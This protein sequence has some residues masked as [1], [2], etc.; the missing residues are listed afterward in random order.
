MSRQ[1][2]DFERISRYTLL[3]SVVNAVPFATSLPTATATVVVTVKD[4]NEAPVFSPVQKLVV[5]KEDLA[6][7]TDTD[8][9]TVTDS[10]VSLYLCV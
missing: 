1:E 4:V 5:K 3:V 10:N 7:V 8:T 6:K 2:L 9:V